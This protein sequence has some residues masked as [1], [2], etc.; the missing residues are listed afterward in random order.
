MSDPVDLLDRAA[1]KL[2]EMARGARLGPWRWEGDFPRRECPCDPLEVDHGPKLVSED[3][4]EVIKAYGYG[5][6]GLDMD[7]GDGYWIAAMSPLVAAP[8]AE[9]LREMSLIY[10]EDPVPR[11]GYGPGEPYDSP[12][13]RFARLILDASPSQAS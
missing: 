2:E 3:S 10:E 6:S 4:F 7:D 5:G 9:W 12:A 13:L 1:S 11:V 8:L